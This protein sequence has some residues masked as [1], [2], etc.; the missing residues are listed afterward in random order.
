MT[1]YAPLYI[2]VA[3]ALLC[4]CACPTARPTQ[5]LLNSCALCALADCI[6]IQTRK[7]ISW[8]ERLRVWAETTRSAK[9]TTMTEAWSAAV[10]AGWCTSTRGMKT[11]LRL[12]FRIYSD[13]RA[14]F[15]GR[16]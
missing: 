9:G 11:L 2:L 16:W 15:S 4:G 1:D 5:G 6:E 14:D 13:G 8:E 7:P 12:T 3:W 10:H